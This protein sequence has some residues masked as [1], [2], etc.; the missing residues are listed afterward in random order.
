MTT[1]NHILSVAVFLFSLS[2]FFSIPLYAQGKP[3]FIRRQNL[4]SRVQT[5]RAEKM[6]DIR[7]LFAKNNV[8]YPP[9][10]IILVSYKK[11]L[12]IELWALPG[13][14]KRYVHMKDYAICNSFYNLDSLPSGELG[15]KRREGDMQIPEGFYRIV[16]FNPVSSYYLSFKIN[17][18]NRSD[19]ILGNPQH[20]GGLIYIH[21][22]CVTIGCIPLKDKWIK[23]L[24]LIAIDTH[25]HTGE[26]SPVYIF[27]TR[28]DDEGMR[29][30]LREANGNRDLLAFWENIKQGY[31][32]FQTTA[33]R[34]K[35]RVSSSGEYIYQE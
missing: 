16:L 34:I 28:M 31:D 26:Q 6:E 5:A 33:R 4:H 10:G 24:Y 20:P 35:F 15:P 19:R 7:N 17:Y 3:E 12:I 22:S 30:L 1:R 8:P 23:E 13:K 25:W 21:G 11:D 27:P 29:F 32:I 9:A 2:V 14:G 18:P